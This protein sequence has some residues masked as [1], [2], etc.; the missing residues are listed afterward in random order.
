MRTPVLKIFPILV[1]FVLNFISA[2][3]QGT[4][5]D[6]STIPKSGTIL[7]YAH[8]DDDLIW[9]LPF[10]KITEKFISGAMPATPRYRTVAQ[11]EQVYLNNNGYNIAYESNWYTPWDDITDVEYSQY[12]LAADPAYNYL[13][14]DHLETRLSSN[15]T[16]L[17]DYEINKIKAKL[18]QF[19]ADPS[20]KR[21][22]THN[23]WGEYGHRHHAG[24]NRAVRELAVKYRKDVWMLGCD[25]GNFTDITVPDGITWTYGSFNMPDLYTSIR[26]IFINN[27]RWTWYTDRVPSGDHKFIKIVD[28]GSDKSSILKGDAITSPGPAQAEAGAY[29]FDGNDDF[30][31][32]KGNNYSS[33]TISLRI[34]PA[35]I[36]AMDIASMSEY[37]GS[38]K[39]DRNMFMT[40]DG[41]ITA[42]IYDGNSRMV[43]SSS[44]VSAAAWSTVTMTDNG[45]TLKLYINGVLDKTIS[46]GTAI[47][48]YSTPE[49]ILG[50]A[51]QTGTYFE[52]QINDVRLYNRV[53]T[54][55]EISQINGKGYTIT[56]SSGTGGTINP[57]GSVA[58]GGGSDLTFSIL[59]N[60]GY[61]I[62]DVKVDNT[63]VGAR[64]SYKF[65][66]ISGNHTIY[67]SFKRISITISANAG[68]GGDISPKGSVSVNYDSDQTFKINANKGYHISDVKIDNVS[69][70]SVSEYTFRDVTSNHTISAGFAKTMYNL[71][72]T[73]G[74]GGKINPE[75]TV[76]VAEGGSQNYTFT[77]DAGFVISDVLLD[78]NSVGAVTVYSFTDINS[79]HAISVIFKPITFDISVASNSGGSVTP[80][81][82]TQVQIGS[83]QSFIITPDYGYKIIQV[84]VDGLPV[85]L[86]SGKYTFKKVVSDHTLTAIFTRLQTFSITSASGKNGSVTPEGTKT[87]FEGDEQSYT[88]TP[89]PG[90]RISNV[91]IDTDPVGP[92]SYYTFNNVYSDHTISAVFSSDVRADIYP[93]PFIDGFT[94]N[95]KSPYSTT[96][97][98]I[99]ETL[100][101]R[102]IYDQM[103]VPSNTPVSV[104]PALPP[105]Y[106]VL[107]VCQ[108]GRVVVSARLIKR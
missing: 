37:P 13:V 85:N 21:V 19:I 65:S 102:K 3:S 24:I 94:L 75:G 51:I 77:P 58:A 18:E 33:F 60:Q 90:F 40:S 12:Y 76:T 15:T 28:A 42:R 59:A 82:P 103:K 107:N 57:S 93:N 89:E 71:K 83:D 100:S 11:Q 99:I 87:V 66:S 46:T 17:S 44:S 79:N 43:T 73:A 63:S 97:R 41:R 68:S 39:N 98:L 31:T 16:N 9:M 10:W 101:N 26:A 25:N 52:G 27:G 47:T 78:N 5:I 34:R 95:I 14:N 96:Y 67:A 88:I 72:G 53:L 2:E 106:Y 49:F 50:Q 105:G 62:T 8:M 1:L 36:K 55:D 70:G 35:R 84:N 22:I 23:N 104:R 91:F 7:I 32:L 69:A 20:M 74:A 38:S 56:A 48:N 81:G 80:G 86:E 6:F 30:M 4:R 64:S 45:S 108:N 61:Q 92:V 54:D 29:I